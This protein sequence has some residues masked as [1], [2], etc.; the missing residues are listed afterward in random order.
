MERVIKLFKKLIKVFIIAIIAIVIVSYMIFLGTTVY[1]VRGIK[2]ADPQVIKVNN[3]KSN[4]HDNKEVH[5]SDEE[6]VIPNAAIEE[7][8]DKKNEKDNKEVSRVEKMREMTNAATSARIIVDDLLKANSIKSFCSNICSQSNYKKISPTLFAQYLNTNPSS[9]LNDSIGIEKVLG[10]ALFSNMLPPRLMDIVIEVA[11]DH[12]RG[13]LDN[14]SASLKIQK[15]MLSLKPFFERTTSDEF[16]ELRRSAA[17][18]LDSYN[19]VRKECS[20]TTIS[21]N[22]AIDRC[23]ELFSSFE[24]SYKKISE[25]K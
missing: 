9:V 8:N 4:K 2:V 17:R 23:E 6:N 11:H 20:E 12:E 7:S 13:I 24:T 1:V 25:I 16:K 21:E 3:K 10:L 14:I 19:V 15:E 5:N 22:D 18:S